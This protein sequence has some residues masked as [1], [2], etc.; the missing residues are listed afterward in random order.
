MEIMSIRR[1]SKGVG[2]LVFSLLAATVA[3]PEILLCPGRLT[4]AR[5]LFNQRVP[6]NPSKF[7]SFC[8]IR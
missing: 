2:S 3:P 1:D 4:F 5:D 7:K 8:N 6:G